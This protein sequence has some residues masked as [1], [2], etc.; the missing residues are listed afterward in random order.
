MFL[1]P[2]RAPPRELRGLALHDV[3]DEGDPQRRF[4]AQLA[5][6]VG[7]LD[8][9]RDGLW[10]GRLQEGVEGLHLEG[11]DVCKGAI[12]QTVFLLFS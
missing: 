6:E 12:C 2:Q 4:D 11:G 8:V 10:K 3:A 5:V 9:A 1:R 7:E